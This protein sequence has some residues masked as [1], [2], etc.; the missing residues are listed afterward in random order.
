MAGFYIPGLDHGTKWSSSTITFSFPQELPAYYPEESYPSFIAFTEVYKELVRSLFVELETILN[1]NFVEATEG[2]GDIAFF[3]AELGPG[4]SA[5][6]QSPGIGDSAGDIRI[7]D[8]KIRNGVVDPESVRSSI[9]HEIGHALG[10]AHPT[11]EVESDNN[12]TMMIP[13]GSFSYNL[14]NDPVH[15]MLYDIAML[16]HLYGANNNHNNE[17]DVYDISAPV[18]AELDAYSIWDTGGN[19]TIT[20]ENS[21][22][23]VKIDLRYGQFSTSSDLQENRDYDLYNNFSIAYDVE[24]EN[25][26]GSRFNDILIGNSLVNHLHGNDGN[27]QIYGGET[28]LIELNQADISGKHFYVGEH[29]YLVHQPSGEDDNDHLIGGKG[30]DELYGGLGDDLL[31]GGEDNDLVVGGKGSDTIVGGVGI[32]VLF[33]ASL[34][35][36]TDDAKDIADFSQLEKGLVYSEVKEGNSP[37]GGFQVTSADGKVNSTLYAIEEVILTKKSDLIEIPTLGD[38]KTFAMGLGDNKVV[39]TNDGSQVSD[40]SATT[41]IDFDLEN[42]TEKQ[43]QHIVG[44]AD[45]DPAL[46]ANGVLTFNGKQIVGGAAFDFNRYEMHTGDFQAY[47]PIL[48]DQQYKPILLTSDWFE[49]KVE[50]VNHL[51]GIASDLAVPGSMLGTPGTGFGFGLGLSFFFGTIA[52]EEKLRW[53]TKW[54]NAYSQEIIGAHGEIYRVYDQETGERTYEVTGSGVY[55]LEISFK[56]DG[57]ATPQTMVVDNWREGDFGITLRADGLRNGYDSGTNRNGVYDVVAGPEDNA[58]IRATLASL[59]LIPPSADPI[60]DAPA[61]FAAAALASDSAAST[62]AATEDTGMP[63]QRNGNAAD[64]NLS[65]SDGNDQ[66]NGGRGDDTLSGGNGVDTYIFARGDGANVI[67]DASAAGNVLKFVDIDTGTLA[68]ADIAGDTDGVSDRQ[69]TFGDGDTVLIKGWSE[70]DQAARDA[71]V[72]ETLTSPDQTPDSEEDLPNLVEYPNELTGGDDADVIY[73]GR[74]EDIITGN[75]G[76]D[77][78]V[79]AGGNDQIFG[80]DGNDRILG[81]TGNDRLFGH[82]G[83]DTILGGA[84]DDYIDSGSGFDEITGGL[85]NDR[86]IAGDHGSN[87]YFNAG[88]GQDTVTVN[89]ATGAYSGGVQTDTLIFGEGISAG[90]IRL[91]RSADDPT[92]ITFEIGDTGDSLRITNQFD[93]SQFD[94]IGNFTDGIDFVRFADGEVWDRARIKDLF[95]DQQTTAGDDILV[96]F[97]NSEDTLVATAGNDTL[98]GGSGNDSYHWNRGSGDDVITDSSGQ[99]RLIFGP[100]IDPADIS[101]EALKFVETIGGLNVYKHDLKITVS[102]PDGGSVYIDNLM[103]ETGEGIDTIIFD[104]GTIWDAGYLAK[105]ALDG[106]TGAGE[107]T[108]YGSAY[109]DQIDGGDGNDTL[110]GG[111]GGDTLLGGEGDDVL[112][113]FDEDTFIGSQDDNVDG[114]DTLNGG[115]GNDVLFGGFGNNRYVFD[116]GFGQDQILTDFATRNTI[117]DNGGS[118]TVVFTAHTLADFELVFTPDADNSESGTLTWQVIGSDDRLDILN[119]PSVLDVSDKSDFVTTYEFADGETLSAVDVA[120]WAQIAGNAGV[121]TRGAAADETLTGGATSDVLI[122]GDGN[123]TLEGGAGDDVLLGNSGDDTVSADSG[124]DRVSG[125]AGNDTLSGDDGNDSVSGGAGDDILSGGAGDD[126]VS[127]GSGADRLAGGAGNDML[128]GG[129]GADTYYFSRGDGQDVI[130]AHTDTVATLDTLVFTQ[131]ITSELV[132]YSLDGADLVVD[133]L[134]GTHDRI[135]IEDYLGNGY[136]TIRYADGSTVTARE[137]L[138]TFTGATDGNDDTR[139]LPDAALQSLIT[140]GKGNDL[141]YENDSVGSN[142]FIFVKGDG[143]D[144]ILAKQGV[145]PETHKLLILGYD[146]EDAYFVQDG[147]NVRIR[148]DGTDDAILL[149]DQLTYIDQW[150]VDSISFGTGGS[151]DRN[152]LR[153]TLVSQQATAGDDVIETS[154]TGTYLDFPTTLEGGEG[155]DTLIGSGNTDT[156]R[157]E[158][159]DGS[160]IINDASTSDASDTLSFGVGIRAQDLGFA[161]S[162]AASDDVVVTLANGSTLTLVGQML[163]GGQGIEQIRFADGGTMS[164]SDI[165]SLVL[166]EASSAGDD[167]LTGTDAGETLA[168]GAGTNTL[169]GGEGGDTYLV[170]A[171]ADTVVETGSSG[172]DQLLLREGVTDED[173]RFWRDPAQTDD[174]VL[175]FTTGETVRVVGQFADNAIERIVFADGKVIDADGIAQRALAGSQSGEDDFVV[176]TGADDRIAAGAGNDVID[177]G[178]GAD[179]VEFARGDGQDR[180]V[181]TDGDT[182]TDILVL[183]TGVAPADVVL[184]AIGA[185]LVLTIKG[186][187]DSLTIEDYF[188]VGGASPVVAGSLGTIAFDDGTVWLADDI[189]ARAVDTAPQTSDD[190][191][192]RTID[193]DAVFV[194]DLPDGLFTD[195]ETAE[196]ALTAHLA[197][198]SD[199]P[200]WLAFEDGQ[201]TGTPQNGDVGTLDIIVAATDATGKQAQAA[202]RLQVDNTNDAPD[203]TSTPAPVAATAGQ[204]LDYVFDVAQISDPDTL[205]GQPG[206][207]ALSFSAKLADGSNLPAWLTFDAEALTFSGQVPA[208][209]S[210]IITVHMFVSDGEAVLTVPLHFVTEADATAPVVANDPADIATAEDAAFSF[211]LPAD[212]FADATQDDVLTISARLADGSALPGWLSFD[213]ATGSFSGTPANEDV[214]VLEIEVSAT[215]LSGNEVATSFLLTVTDTND[216]PTVSGT[217]NAYVA[218]EGEQLD[219]APDYTVFSDQDQ[220]DQLSYSATLFGGDP[221]PAWL[222]FDGQKFTGTPEDADTGIIALS[223]IATDGSSATAQQSFYMVVAAVN[224]APVAVGAIADQ[225]LHEDDTLSFTLPEGLFEDADNAGHALTLSLDNGDPLPDWI[226]YDPATRTVHSDPPYDLLDLYEGSRT[227]T[228]KVTATDALGASTSLTFDLSIYDDNPG[229][230]VTG[231]DGDDEL[232]GSNGPDVLDGGA[233]ND[234]LQGSFGKDTFLFGPGSGN[235]TIDPDIPVYSSDSVGDTIRF[236]GGLTAADVEITRTGS[237]DNLTDLVITITATGETLTV[238]DQFGILGELKNVIT[239]FEFEDGTVWNDDDILARFTTATDQADTLQGDGFDNVLSGGLGDDRLNGSYGDDVLHGGEGSDVLDGGSGDDTYVLE[240]GGGIDMIVADSKSTDTNYI[241]F[242]DGIVPADLVIY[243]NLDDSDTLS[244]PVGIDLEPYEMY[245]G[246]ADGSAG[247]VVENQFKTGFVDDGISGYR[248]QDGSVYL[249][250]QLVPLTAGGN[251]G[252]LVEGTAG[253]DTLRTAFGD[254]TFDGGEGDDTVEGGAGDDTILYNLGDGND[255]IRDDGEALSFDRLVFGEGIN[256]EDVKFVRASWLSLDIEILPTGEVLRLNSFFTLNSKGFYEVPIDEILFGNGDSL[257]YQNVVDLMKQGSSGDDNL[258]GLEYENDILDGGSGDDYLEGFG[259]DDTYVFGLGYGSDTVYADNR[260]IWNV[261]NVTTVEFKD[262]LTLDDLEFSFDEAS[263]RWQARISGTDDVLT[264]N[265]GETVHVSHAWVFTFDGGERVYHSELITRHL[266]ENGLHEDGDTVVDGT[267]GDDTLTGTSADEVFTGGTGNDHIKSSSG[268]D[269]FI[270]N[271]NDGSDRIEDTSKSVF[272]TDVLRL[273]GFS[274]NEVKLGRDGDDLIILFDSS[275]DYITVDDQ[276]YYGTYSHYYNGERTTFDNYRGLEAIVFDDGSFL[277]RHDIKAQARLTGNPTDDETI[278]GTSGSDT[279]HISRN[280]G[281]DV[282]KAGGGSAGEVDRLVLGPNIL[283]GDVSFSRVNDSDD[284]LISIGTSEGSVTIRDQFA[285]ASHGV[286]EIEFSDG[287]IL[288]RQAILET[289]LHISEGDDDILGSGENDTLNGLGGQDQI[290]GGNGDDLIEGGSGN[291]T[292]TGGAG[293]DVL[294]GGLGDDVMSGGDGSDTYRFG[295]GEGADT[296]NDQGSDLEEFDTLLL[297]AGIRT[298]DVTVERSADGEDL[299]LNIGADGDQVTLQDRLVSGSAGVDLVEFEDGTVWNYDALLKL[300]DGT[301]Y[302]APVGTD[303]ILLRAPGGQ[304]VTIDPASLLINDT[305]ADGDTLFVQSVGGATQGTVSIDEFGMVR[306]G[307]DTPF[308]TG[309]V[310]FTY[311]VSDGLYTSDTTVTVRFGAFDNTAPITTDDGDLTV[312]QGASLV[313]TT[314]SLL[315]NDTDLDGDAIEFFALGTSQNGSVVLDEN[316]DIRFTPTAGFSGS[317]TFGYTISDGR[318]GTATGTVNVEVLPAE[319]DPPIVNTPMETQIFAEDSE[320]NFSV[321]AATFVDPDGDALTFSATLGDGSDLPAWLSFDAAT[322]TFSGT[323]PQDFNGTLSLK[324]VAS[325]GTASAEDVFDLV[326]DPV[327]DAPVTANSLNDQTGTEDSAWSFTVPADAFSDVDGDALSY[328]AV[329][330]DGSALPAWLNFDGATRSFSGT[331][332]QDFN[333][334]LSLKVI[335]TDGTASAEGLF[336]LAID[337]VNDAPVVAVGIA[338]QSGTEDSAWSFTVPADTFSDADGD[339]LSYSAVLA[340]GSALPSWLS[341][342]AATR[343]FSGTPPQDFN[344]ALSLKVIGTDGTASAESPF[345]LAIDPVNDAPVVANAIVEQSGTENSAWSFTVPADA[346]SDADGDALT[347]SATLGDGSDLPSWL[348]FDAATRTFSGTPPQ[349]FNGTVSLKVVASDGTASAEDA[350]D[351]VIDPV[352]DAPVVTS[353]VADQTGT[354]DTAWS[355]TVP[356]DAFSDVD[357][358][359]LSYS[360]VLADGSALPSWLNFDGATRSFSGTP[361]QDFNGALSLKIIA[362]DGTAS[363]EEIFS[364]SIDPVNDAPVVAIGIADQSG[365]EDAAWSFTVPADTFSDA[366]GDTLSYSAVLADGSAL[367]AWLNFDAANRS[368][369]GTPPQDFNGALSL[370]VIATDGAASAESLFELAIDPVNDAPVVTNAIADQSGTE[371]RAW[372]F[373]VPADAFSDEDGDELT[374]SAELSDGSALPSWLGFDAATRTFFGTPPQDF[375][376]TL[377]LKVLASDGTASAESVFDLVVDPSDPVT[378]NTIEKVSGGSDWSNGIASSLEGLTGAGYFQ[379]TMVDGSKDVDIGVSVAGSQTD[380]SLDYYIWLKGGTEVLIR[381]NGDFVADFGAYSDGDTFAIERLADGGLRY[382]KNGTVFYTSANSVDPSIALH[383]HMSLYDEGTK[384]SNTVISTD[385]GEPQLV[386]WQLDDTLEVVP[387][388]ATELPTPTYV[389]TDEADGEVWLTGDDDV[390]DTGAGDEYVNAGGGND[391]FLWTKGDGNDSFGAGGNAENDTDIVIFTDVT[392]SDV[393]FSVLW[394]KHITVTVNSTGEVVTLADQLG[395]FEEPIDEIRFSDGV[396]YTFS[397][398]SALALVGEVGNTAD[399]AAAYGDLSASVTGTID[400]EDDQDWYAVELVAGTLYRFQMRGSPT[401]DGTLTDPELALRDANGV[402]LLYDDDGGEGYNSQLEYTALE[403]GTY[404]IDAGGRDENTGTFTLE[405]EEYANEVGDTVAGAAAYG[406]LSAPVTGTIDLEDDQDWYQVELVA[407]TLYQFHMLGSPTGDGT[408][409]DPELALRDANGVELLYDDDG[410][411][412]YNSRLEFHATESGTYYI[413]AGGRNENIGTFTLNVEEY[414]NE[415]GDTADHAVTYGDLGASV[416]GTIDFEDDQDWYQVQLDAG[417][418]Y[419]FHMRGSPTG[420]GTLSDPELALRDANGDELLYDDD[421]GDGYNSRLEFTALESGTY[422]IDAGGRN[423]NTGT[424]ALEIETVAAQTLVGDAGDNLLEGAAANDILAGGAGSDIL[425]GGDGSDTFRFIAGETGHDTITDFVAGEGSDDMIEFA[426]SIFTDMASVLAAAADDG[427]DTTITFDGNTSIQ[428]EDILVSELHQDDFLFV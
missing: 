94:P 53:D 36:V 410:G 195:A 358:D 164:G 95:L 228:V 240:L 241:S 147:D 271:R 194:L 124:D 170:G 322:R 66:F 361:P 426:T 314:A 130:S 15:L 305:D 52:T 299:I 67:F 207:E 384:L 133:F 275:D 388:T 12:F 185:D 93:I 246:L 369:S 19:D 138:A 282:I 27:D 204:A 85:G 109:G 249:L 135:T 352:N 406:D 274:S 291:D 312:L 11:G 148:F 120:K 46:A 119:H 286:R 311:V 424:F 161:R 407:G 134:N 264:F 48:S 177:L 179:V 420:D 112:H 344:G 350:F 325:D 58:Q 367:P 220:G 96:G 318:G 356:A 200:T 378:G 392:S 315:A 163:G 377:S 293:E 62:A 206:T 337:P 157:Y 73:G 276:F 332:P 251:G 89:D 334:T 104:D 106:Q 181:A 72:F 51:L 326:I 209:S 409:S 37:T 156:Y 5:E 269:T 292:L 346:F 351:L 9:L 125:G 75:G 79:G 28:V 391:T 84:N 400:F 202:F 32:D 59:G 50:N 302:A 336:E 128:E 397:Q 196:L 298:T 423:E 45:L 329:L 370:K 35:E 193:E 122:G 29:Y 146:R 245:I 306:L 372:S 165:R 316:G 108:V 18:N 145:I 386:T 205:N 74:K 335:A 7:S 296:I 172:T 121:V 150:G 227:Y 250:N 199:L 92:A 117:G 255:S 99:D 198:G 123:D 159:G 129:D 34:D 260:N 2:V 382:L 70:L 402:E 63:L 102:G 140:G 279:F 266:L 345:E 301:A 107:D 69:I 365:T 393:S 412:G 78:L 425:S 213:V 368:F 21:A 110:Y 23:F 401:G 287:S 212:V 98:A 395:G 22:N 379:S 166:M 254:T 203:L 169:I 258:S 348:S 288:D 323:P 399:R 24:I 101:V 80:N 234:L 342:D 113:G 421:G 224:D 328:G 192:D 236:T 333:G 362:T 139:D 25:A 33:G 247:F 87:I 68:F 413:D 1:I 190:L 16:Q 327:N 320:V 44:N 394:D 280:F 281:D 158:L 219:W 414:A 189:L 380:S 144:Q 77:T 226:T 285:D 405:V 223:V 20:A 218:T 97:K 263:D 60:D 303:D 232:L 366:D 143:E 88:D 42:A 324:V 171:G 353:P 57:F 216:A 237:N 295:L 65:G 398:F 17:D 38:G 40:P 137:V 61:A 360:A 173:I 55:R 115:A 259:G 364:L 381:E 233:G 317:A 229:T 100:G 239:Q 64:N 201:F 82:G 39:V 248:F 419:V 31:D 278:S 389:G 91:V 261:P 103:K 242:G 417:S 81:G 105:L 235:D 321:P 267:T 357:G 339:T 262:G 244:I 294:S 270:Y 114:G 341:F 13:G 132:T 304:W 404:Y 126:H 141:L 300:S 330:A 167:T 354:E 191:A 340:D 174:L 43:T 221:L 308:A 149:P 428:L 307:G 374:Y 197:N 284:L 180:I 155:N 387:E 217:W 396:S 273:E 211:T 3:G 215:D 256:I 290:D 10:L 54:V 373:T 83:E 184:T 265:M 116:A 297:T 154:A 131:G 277:S 427:T 422:Y 142:T 178:T 225:S 183:K 222:D 349:D 390:I 243:G 90:D 383:A 331:P 230:T 153:Q 168:G 403:S 415:A 186:T 359:A 47:T 343:T 238:L 411:E 272:E 289:V 210:G 111:G 4:V 418:L 347:Y 118:D 182:D 30:N 136:L 385:G 152:Q 160:D 76:D 188:D 175:S 252:G 8:H 376:G 363:A 14:T 127:G 319:N 71:W 355:F 151:L 6:A 371:D 310:T 309:D 86:I 268:S 313:V 41:R 162:G 176:G 408:L 231:T 26:R 49:A 214:G 338:D 187:A 56:G 375:D 257:T 253:A 208:G 416:T 283:L